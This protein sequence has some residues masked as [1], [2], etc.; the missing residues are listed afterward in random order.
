MIAVWNLNL[1]E[2]L[3][4]SSHAFWVTPSCATKPA[5]SEYPSALP[6]HKPDICEP[7]GL[8]VAPLAWFLPKR[9]RKILKMHENVIS[10]NLECLE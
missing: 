8:A 9:I 4:A 1:S 6:N 10:T 2:T 7:K 5:K 3:G